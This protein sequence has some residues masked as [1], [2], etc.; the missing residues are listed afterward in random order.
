[1]VRCEKAPI[2]HLKLFLM[3]MNLGNPFCLIQQRFSSSKTSKYWLTI[4]AKLLQIIARNLCIRI[5]PYTLYNCGPVLRVS[6]AYFNYFRTN[7][8]QFETCLVNHGLRLYYK[9]EL[10][11]ELRMKL[12]TQ[13]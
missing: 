10:V 3:V 9:I 11:S 8:I 12:N 6:L 7:S 4:F 5:S 1:M 2:K 13:S